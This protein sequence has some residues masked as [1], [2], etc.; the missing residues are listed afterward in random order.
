MADVVDIETA[1]SPPTASFRAV[2]PPILWRVGQMIGESD[3]VYV[4]NFQ[5][6]GETAEKFPQSYRLRSGNSSKQFES[7]VCFPFIHSSLSA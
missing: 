4:S 5:V 3:L 7:Y 1:V 6:I 2:E